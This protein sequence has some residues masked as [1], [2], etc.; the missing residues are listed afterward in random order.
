MAL[1][2]RVRLEDFPNSPYARELRDGVKLRFAPRLEEIYR[3]S[4]LQR[5]RV[6]VRLWISL[7]AAIALMDGFT[8]LSA[9]PAVLGT[10]RWAAA[11]ADASAL[12]LALIVW[13]RHY[14]RLYLP[15]A[16]L[17]MPLSTGAI[18]VLIAH[19]ILEGQ[20][21]QLA[22][23]TINILAVFFFTGLLFRA[24]LITSLVIAAALL[25]TL[26]VG[27]AAPAMLLPSLF[28]LSMMLLLCIVGY[29]DIEQS[30]RRSFLETALI[31]EL[32]ARDELS[33]LASRPAFDEHLGRLWPQAQHAGRT[34]AVLMVDIDHFKAYNDTHGHQGGDAALRAVAQL[35]K[36]VARRPLDL[37]GRYGGDEFVAVLYDLP[38][39][40]VREIAERLRQSVEKEV[41]SGTRP[42]AAA[43]TISIGAAVVIPGEGRSAQ[44][45]VQLA[46]EALYEA[47]QGG[48]N[49]VVLKGM[50]E[51][52]RLD[53][54]SYRTT[55][56]APV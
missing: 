45:A 5:V 11:L 50:E 22:I 55:V 17:V 6:R 20:G 1:P 25:G 53:T 9:V 42:D 33:G 21:E 2:D 3:H 7:I 38:V 46:D 48:R 39:E 29:R 24:A 19:R 23:V 4:H 31:A 15:L 26:L 14:A 13:S 35:L 40:R 47:K 51:Y 56:T 16:R 37:A 30:H 10:P 49:R 32:V 43:V 41:R 44:G 54:G 27:G 12:A 18:A 34:L 8:R 36:A 52:R 28:M